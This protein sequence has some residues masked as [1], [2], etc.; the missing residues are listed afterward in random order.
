MQAVVESQRTQTDWTAYLIPL[1]IKYRYRKPIRHILERRIRRME[2]YLFLRKTGLSFQERMEH[3]KAVLLHRQEIA[4]DLKLALDRL[5]ELSERVKEVREAILSQ[6]EEK[7]AGP[8][9]PSQAQPMDR[10][11]RLSSRL[12]S[13]P[14][15]MGKL[16]ATIQEQIRTDLASLKRNVQMGSWQP[17][18]VDWDPSQ[19]RLAETVLKLEREVYQ[20]QRPRQLANRDVFLRVGEPIDLGRFVTAYLKDA[21]SV[22]HLV[23]EQ[24]R[25]QIQA[26][27]DTMAAV[28]PASSEVR[29]DEPER[30]AT[31]RS[32]SCSESESSWDQPKPQEAGQ[33]GRPGASFS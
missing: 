28:P 15:Q 24:L 16:G 18:Y 26:L 21:R 23:A 25:D 30:G 22:R 32:E 8:T 20:V 5:T 2:H 9:V 12:R 10:A 7:Y 29:S 4:H 6:L 1:A 27:I 3:I 13:L 11:W 17:Q 33:S 14:T 31:E 19:E